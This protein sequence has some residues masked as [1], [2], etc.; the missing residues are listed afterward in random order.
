MGM[1]NSDNDSEDSNDE[2]NW[3]NEYPDSDDMGDDDKSSI[4]EEDIRRAMKYID[5]GNYIIFFL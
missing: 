1:Q 4:G 5:I 3:R 2:N